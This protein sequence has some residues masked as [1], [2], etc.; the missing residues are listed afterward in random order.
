MRTMS[1][2]KEG[3]RWRYLWTKGLPHPR[4]GRRSRQGRCHQLPYEYAG[5]TDLV[6]PELPLPIG[7]GGLFLSSSTKS[8]CPEPVSFFPL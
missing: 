6:M 8:F 7:G 3:S 2:V 1:D 5:D 4:A